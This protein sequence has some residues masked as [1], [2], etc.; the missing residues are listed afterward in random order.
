MLNDSSKLSSGVSAPTSVKAAKGKLPHPIAAF[1]VTLASFIGSSIVASIILSLIVSTGDSGK[2][3]LFGSEIVL[4]FSYM[5]LAYG[6]ML[7]AVLVFMRWKKY[8]LGAVGLVRPKLKDLGLAALAFL[9][10]IGIYI[11]LVSFVEQLL[12]SIDLDQKQDIGFD[13]AQGAALAFIFVML[14][15]VVPFVEEFLMR[16]LL[17]SSLRRRSSYWLAAI[18]TSVMFAVLHLG[19]GEAGAGPLW[20]AAIDTFVL[21]LVLCY[22]RERT[23]RL[24]AGIGL[25]SIKNCIAFMALFIFVG[26]NT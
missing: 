17:F 2:S 24:W 18:I 22:L 15:I 5:L 8:S 19:G 3:E 26:S 21:S 25:H 4:Q 23:G 7:G 12:P 20:I 9:V 11:I 1:L 10:Y 14:V 6:V 13:N 16:G